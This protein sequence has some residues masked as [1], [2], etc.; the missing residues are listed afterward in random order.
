MW[1]CAFTGG[2]SS[3]R[4]SAVYAVDGA[5]LSQVAGCLEK[6]AGLTGVAGLTVKTLQRDYLRSFDRS[7][8][9]QRKV[10]PRN[11]WSPDAALKVDFTTEHLEPASTSPPPVKAIHSDAD[12]PQ[13]MAVRLG[14]ESPEA[15]ANDPERSSSDGIPG[16]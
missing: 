4:L 2:G 7:R 3:G 1:S 6:L 10:T 5:T 13:H 11:G 8:V 16:S 12:E 14:A 15:S 9:P